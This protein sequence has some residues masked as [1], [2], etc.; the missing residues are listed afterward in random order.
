MCDH[1]ID[2]LNDNVIVLNFVLI[3]KCAVAGPEPL[4]PT[5]SCITSSKCLPVHLDNVR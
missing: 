2:K 1:D 5:M 3:K 4:N